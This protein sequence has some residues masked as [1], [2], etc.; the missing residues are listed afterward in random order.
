VQGKTDDHLI[1]NNR[2]F[3]RPVEDVHA[4]GMTS[5]H[6]CIWL[7]G[8]KL[9]GEI[10]LRDCDNQISLEFWAGEG[11]KPGGVNRMSDA[12]IQIRDELD[13]F[14][15]AYERAAEDL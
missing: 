10:H 5:L 8:K 3:L 12:L 7:D 2:F 1:H 11:A 13:D 6:S 4:G 9:R 15:D 14:I